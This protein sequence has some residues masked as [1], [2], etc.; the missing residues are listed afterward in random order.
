MVRY[1]SSPLRHAYLANPAHRSRSR[2]TKHTQWS[3]A[4][5]E[6]TEFC[7][8]SRA[9]REEW[10]HAEG[11]FWG[12]KLSATTRNELET[13][14]DTQLHCGRVAKW[15]RFV[16]ETH[17]PIWHGYPTWPDP[18][19]PLPPQNVLLDWSS[20]RPLSRAKVARLLRGRKCE[21]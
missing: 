7:I 12:V 8:F 10:G 17:P 19:R 16:A 14:N 1:T 5:D 18:D 20:Y 13:L 4:I 6:A 2:S 11:S 3:R 15:C 9:V 21:F